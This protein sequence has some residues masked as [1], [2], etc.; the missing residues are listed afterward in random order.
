MT[1]KGECNW[2]SNSFV[3]AAEQVCLQPVFE[4]RQRRGRGNFAWQ[5]IPHLCSSNRKG[6][7]SNSWP[8]TGRNVKLFGGSGPEPA[9]V[10]H[11]GDTCE[12]RSQ[13]HIM[14][15]CQS[16]CS[17]VCSS[18]AG[19]YK[20]AKHIVRPLG[21]PISIWL[22]RI[23]SDNNFLPADLWSYEVRRGQCGVTQRP[24][25]ATP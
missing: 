3:T 10:R 16:V 20:T 23:R 19:S 22:D 12:W 14:A 7:T 8:T 13:E 24:H 4:H 5:A 9:S 15:I 1:R 25:M 2:K 6:T 17:C 18:Q 11:V 21:R